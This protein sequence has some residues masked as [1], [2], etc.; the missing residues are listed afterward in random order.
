M[1]LIFK[2]II[3]KKIKGRGYNAKINRQIKRLKK[4]EYDRKKSYPYILIYTSL[5]NKLN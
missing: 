5:E 4:E 2:Y 3:V 1:V